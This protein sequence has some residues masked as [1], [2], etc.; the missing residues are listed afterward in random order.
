M[1]DSEILD[2]FVARSEEAIEQIKK[3]YG[4]YCKS[5]AYHILFNHEDAEECLSDTWLSAWNA[6]PPMR[7]QIL[8][9][10]LGKL[11]RNHALDQY[12]KNSAK[13]RGGSQVELVLEEL[14]ECTSTN[15]RLEDDIIDR[16][17][18][19]QILNQFLESVSEQYIYQKQRQ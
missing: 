2:L 8:A 3:K 6:I 19:E 18:L 5:I 1:E 7:P 16:N 13:K 12:R 9:T 11:T 14:N 10:Y 4:N 15:N 17:A